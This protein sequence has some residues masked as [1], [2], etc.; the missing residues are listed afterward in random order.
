MY[1]IDVILELVFIILGQFLQIINI[2][3][4][5]LMNIIFKS[6]YRYLTIN[7]LISWTFI[8]RTLS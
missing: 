5:V 8:F 3:K 4:F 1:K 6:P 2:D 7:S